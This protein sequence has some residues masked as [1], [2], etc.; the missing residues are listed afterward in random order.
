MNKRLYFPYPPAVVCLAFLL[1]LPASPLVAEPQ[2]QYTMVSGQRNIVDIANAGDSSNRV[3]LVEQ[4]GRVFIMKDGV[5]L[6]TPF[7][8]M[9]GRL[10]NAN[11]QGLLSIAFAPDYAVSGNFYVWY[12][13][14]A[15]GSVLSRFKVSDDPDVADPGSEEIV[16]TVNQPYENHNG[17]RLQFGPDGMLYLG[18]GDGGASN[19]PEQRAQDGSTLLGKLIR[20]DVNPAISPYA[21]P[22]D[23]PFI[24]DAGV[25][26]EI[27]ALGLRNP[28][29]ISFDQETGDLFIADVGQNRLEEVSFQP[30]DST[31]G[32]NY[33]WDRMEGTRC[34]GGSCNP[35]VF[36]LP[37]A[38]YGHDDGCSITGGEVYRGSAY[39][40][41]YGSYL[42]GD[43][44]SGKVWR[45]TR[46][47]N[48]WTAERMS[49]FRTTLSTFGLG[50]DGSIYVSAT[51]S[52]IYLVSDG[53][54]KSETFTIN[55][56][57]NDAWYNPVTS[58]QGFFIIVFPEIGQIFLSWFT[59]D[60]ERADPPPAAQLGE[61]YHRW[62]TAQGPYA[63]NQAVLTVSVTSGGIFDA[64]LPLPV[65][66][67][68][69]EIIVEFSSCRAGKISYNI[70]SIDMQ[71]VV[72]IE[73]VAPDNIALCE[74]LSTQLAR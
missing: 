8:S 10:S 23:N 31:G 17:G 60:T 40:E 4:T 66:I 22:T 57:L 70:P 39:P 69:G 11:E 20:I 38:E 46:D 9:Q 14:I 54:V 52:G 5:T 68:D 73:R 62:I 27:W 37:V 53:E 7:L 26:N 56:G 55:P 74:A 15:G 67:S 36:T 61:A 64:P 35:A 13:Q 30:A 51:N 58:G 29:K 2:L 3:F 45:L 12:T 44:C 63:D 19:D 50:E 34:I 65:S 18:L 43:Y 49:D 28:W 48:Q 72:P 47:G 41:L 16:L 6:E 24:N 71:G 21:I 59:Y 32:E 33:G 25:R 1:L 42:Y